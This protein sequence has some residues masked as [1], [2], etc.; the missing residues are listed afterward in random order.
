MG[1]AN[2]LGG[3]GGGGIRQK[4]IT[5][6]AYDALSKAE[7]ENEYIVWIISNPKKSAIGSGMSVDNLTVKATIW[8]TYQSLSVDDKLDPHVQWII[9]DKNIEDLAAM[10]F[11][12]QNVGQGS[13][14]YNIAAEMDHAQLVEAYVQ[15][16]HRVSEIETSLV[17]ISEILNG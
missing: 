5:Q 17:R 2:L 15:L 10:G 7:R 4:T 14:L 3:A 6:E 13:S 11:G 12:A 8:N 1:Q 16:A 9:T